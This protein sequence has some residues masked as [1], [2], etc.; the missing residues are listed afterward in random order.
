MVLAVDYRLMPE[1]SR[2]D[3]ITDCQTAYRWLL[4]QCIPA[5]DRELAVGDALSLKLSDEFFR[6]LGK[7]YVALHPPKEESHA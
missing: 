7:H 3:G 4:E 1:H 5:L 6:V 2:M